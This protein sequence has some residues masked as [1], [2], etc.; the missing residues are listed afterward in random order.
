MINLLDI[1]IAK[2][3]VNKETKTRDSKAMGGIKETDSVS[4]QILSM[5]SKVQLLMITVPH[6][7]ANSVPTPTADPEISLMDPTVKETIGE[8]KEE[9]ISDSKETRIEHRIVDLQNNMEDRNAKETKI[10]T[11][12][13]TMDLDQGE[14]MILEE[15]VFLTTISINLPSLHF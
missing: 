15:S 11:I 5:I 12:S 7:P 8:T 4:V 13:G 14:M 10:R 3:L 9:M 6:H 2:A 1:K